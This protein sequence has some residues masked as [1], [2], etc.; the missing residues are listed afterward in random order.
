MNIK[1]GRAGRWAVVVVTSAAAISLT[2]TPAMAEPQH[3]STINTRE[4]LSVPYVPGDCSGW[5]V[6]NGTVVQMQCWQG[7]P[8]AMGQGKWF[9]VTVVQAAG[10]GESGEV[11]AP[12][13]SNQWLSSPHC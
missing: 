6:G 5:I 2:A 13:V 9:E 10:Y 1:T 11:P 3:N 4:C 7:G 8:Q 12:S